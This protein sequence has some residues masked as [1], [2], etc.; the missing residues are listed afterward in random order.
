MDC[1]TCSKCGE[2]KESTLF[3]PNRR[4]CKQCIFAQNYA[5]QA[6]NIEK[7]RSYT[8]KSHHKHYDE[9]RE[10]ILIRH[11]L[12]RAENKEW[13]STYNKQYALENPHI[14][15]LHRKLRVQILKVQCPSWANQSK[16]QSLYKEARRLTRETGIRHTVDHI[17]PLQGKIVSGLH[18]ETNLQILTKSE[19][20]RKSNNY[21]DPDH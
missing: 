7:K 14:L 12:W 20:S 5:W 15:A 16:I 3:Y 4:A 10:E 1:K 9:K 21:V 6:K 17:L 2:L 18:V 19:N 13:M 8:R 11:K